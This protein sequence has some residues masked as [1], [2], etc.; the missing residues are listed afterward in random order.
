MSFFYGKAKEDI[1]NG[2]GVVFTADTM[3]CVLVDL[4]LYTPNENGDH[5][6]SDIPVGARIS[7]T[8]ALTGKGN[9][10]GVLSCADTSFPGT[11]GGTTCGAFV[12]FKD[13]GVAGTSPLLIFVD[14]AASGLPVTTDGSAINCSFQ[15][16]SP[17]LGEI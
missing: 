2:A 10:L 17:K 8:L 14:T 6:L 11:A 5:F 7:T 9:S 16:T 3:K 15:A 12:V 13:T 1:M 4:A